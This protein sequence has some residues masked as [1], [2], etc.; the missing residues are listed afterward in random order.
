MNTDIVRKNI[1]TFSNAYGH[2][3]QSLDR[4]FAS[5]AWKQG[6]V[7]RIGVMLR[8]PVTKQQL[9]L[10][11][12]PVEEDVSE[13]MLFPMISERSLEAVVIYK[14]NHTGTRS[15]KHPDEYFFQ[16][17]SFNLRVNKLFVL[18]GVIQKYFHEKAYGFIQKTRRGI[19]FMKHWTDI[20]NITEGQKVSFVP[21]IT[22]K[23]LQARG[24][25]NVK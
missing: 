19:F 10:C 2:K 21:L 14:K 1:G 15:L 9:I 18:N 6:A 11:D 24:I 17:E 25:R 3:I 23:G 8:D 4:L 5:N 13:Y 20:E 16:Q 12:F 22:R 7:L